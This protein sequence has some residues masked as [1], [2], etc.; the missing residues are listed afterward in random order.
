MLN[1]LQGKVMRLDVPRTF[2]HLTVRRLTDKSRE[3]LEARDWMS[4][5]SYHSEVWQAPGAIV[6]DAPAKLQWDTIVLTPTHVSY[7]YV[8]IS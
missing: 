3:A 4:E 5:G 1:K 7:V 2:I 6:A 8:I